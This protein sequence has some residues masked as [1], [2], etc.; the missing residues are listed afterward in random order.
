[1]NKLTPCKVLSDEKHH[2]QET[3]DDEPLSE[4]VLMILANRRTCELCGG[5]AGCQYQRIRPHQTGN[6]DVLPRGNAMEHDERAAEAGK[7]HDD[8]GQ[9]NI[10]PDLG[11]RYRERSAGTSGASTIARWRRRNASPAPLCKNSH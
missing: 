2:P 5:A 11:R 9:Q 7:Q 8:C 4:N 3:A 6:G 10:R 1:M